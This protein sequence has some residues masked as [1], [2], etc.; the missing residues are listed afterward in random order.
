MVTPQLSQLGPDPLEEGEKENALRSEFE[1]LMTECMNA[2]NR[3]RKA[4]LRRQMAVIASQLSQ[5]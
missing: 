3:S 5:S 1:R 2:V 4:A